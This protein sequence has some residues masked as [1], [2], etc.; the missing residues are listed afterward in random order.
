MIMQDIN[1]G[2]G[3]TVLDPHGT[4]IIVLL[5]ILLYAILLIKVVF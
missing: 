4:L 5:L 3:V 2:R 1:K